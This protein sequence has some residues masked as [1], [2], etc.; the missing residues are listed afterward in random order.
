[1][2]NSLTWIGYALLLLGWIKTLTPDFVNFLTW[3]GARGARRSQ[4]LI[5]S[6]R[7]PIVGIPRPTKLWQLLLTNLCLFIARRNVIW[8]E[9]MIK[10][11]STW[12]IVEPSEQKVE[13]KRGRHKWEGAE[14]EGNQGY[15]WLAHLLEMQKIK[16]SNCSHYVYI[17]IKNL[18]LKSPQIVINTLPHNITL[19]TISTLLTQQPTKANINV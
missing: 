8:R 6:R 19:I 15:T 17:E 16:Q 7:I 10:V 12:P 18:R 5:V 14:K 2:M 13:M 3:T 11:N 4:A 1:M 9:K